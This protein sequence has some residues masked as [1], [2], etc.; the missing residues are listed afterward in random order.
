MSE[1][2][3]GNRGSKSGALAQVKEQRVDGNKCFNTRHLRYTL[4]GCESSF[5]VKIPSKL[6]INKRFYSSNVKQS[7]SN[8]AVA[9]ETTRR[10]LNPWFVS[11]FIDAEGSFIVIVRKNP[12]YRIG[13]TVV[14]I[15]SI[16]L[17]ERDIC[18]LQE[19]Q[20]YFG[21]A[22]SISKSGQN[23]FK[24]RI[25]S[26]ELI[27]NLIIPHFDKY[28]LVTQKLGDYLLFKTVVEMMKAKGHLTE[29]GIN[30]IVAIKAS[31]NNGLSADLHA[32]FPNLN[33][34]ARPIVD[35][36]KV[37]HEEWIAG[38]TSG[39]CC[40]YVVVAKSPSR[41]VGFRV[42]LE[43]KISQHERDEKL[44]ASLI[45]YYGSGFL[46][47]DPRGA[48][49]YTVCNFSE[50]CE[51]IIPFFQKHKIRGVKSEDFADWCKIAELIKVKDHLTFSGLDQI[52]KIKSG[53]NKGRYN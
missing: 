22:G 27:S 42:L 44:M 18:I 24:Y 1:N 38:F 6:N 53:M 28:P 41:K 3:I 17:H 43:L 39:E 34:V 11:G 15:F 37:P 49:V 30:K 40:F 35:N 29:V 14:V 31:M 50:I 4:M 23:T 2:E 7:F 45:T 47:K 8:R 32:A 25:E 10:I 12:K 51:K 48:R 26:L 19:I 52:R 9:G 36:K 20:A 5:K 16:T 21:G 33:P 13:W 46:K